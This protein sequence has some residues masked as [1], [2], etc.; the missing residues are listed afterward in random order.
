MLEHITSCENFYSSQIW[1]LA[2]GG[3]FIVL[4]LI[5][6]ATSSTY[7]NHSQAISLYILLALICGTLYWSSR[8]SYITIA[9]PSTKMKINVAKMKK[10]QVL[11]FINKVE[12]AKHKRISGLNNRS[13]FIN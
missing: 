2:L 7:D 12:L 4:G 9:S 3:L 13:N 10:Q 11:D 5:T 8:R 6:G 1:L